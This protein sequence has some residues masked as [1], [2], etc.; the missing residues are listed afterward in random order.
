M[1]SLI[2][3]DTVLT[4]AHCFQS[5]S[6]DPG[7]VR[8]GGHDLRQEDGNHLDVSV[9]EV[10]IHPAWDPATLQNDIALVKMSTNVTFNE[11]REYRILHSVTFLKLSNFHQRN[12][13]TFLFC[14]FLI[15][16]NIKFI[17][18]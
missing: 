6:R 18:S 13:Q 12:L 14:I 11:V 2:S 15:F 16:L 7:T 3:R 9:R 8:L 4:A 17:D 5:G 10:V 1:Y